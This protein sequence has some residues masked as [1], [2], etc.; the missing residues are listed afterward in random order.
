MDVTR[1]RQPLTLLVTNVKGFLTQSVLKK[2]TEVHQH[3]KDVFTPNINFALFCFASCRAGQLTGHDSVSLLGSLGYKCEG[4][5]EFLIVQTQW[6]HFF[7][8]QG[9][10][11]PPP[12][13]VSPWMRPRQERKNPWWA[14]PLSHLV[15]SFLSQNVQKY[16]KHLAKHELGIQISTQVLLLS[17]SEIKT[18]KN[19]SG[20][21]LV[22][23]DSDDS[24]S[25]WSAERTL[26]RPVRKQDPI[27]LHEHLQL[28]AEE[29][30]RSPFVNES[31]HCHKKT[32]KGACEWCETFVQE[33]KTSV[34]PHTFRRKKPEV[35]HMSTMSEEAIS[36]PFSCFVH[37]FLEWWKMIM[38]TMKAQRKGFVI[39]IH[40]K[41]E[42]KQHCAMQLHAVIRRTHS[43]R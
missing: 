12:T 38:F 14:S 24:D 19:V 1:G 40:V 25:E 10:Y 2:T 7:I 37:F 3:H 4:V 43:V 16:G 34:F 22:V 29:V 36:T 32:A 6:D 17:L 30:S 33:S 23:D 5:L 15:L 31:F 11:R 28:S 9:C 39:V 13:S 42:E 26:W 27:T 35:G 41:G 21:L 18:H 20:D 8:S